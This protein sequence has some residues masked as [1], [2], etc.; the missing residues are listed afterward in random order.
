LPR[1]S[2]PPP[3]RT[4]AGCPIR[5]A[6][7]TAARD[8]EGSG[9]GVAFLYLP[10]VVGADRPPGWDRWLPA[11]RVEHLLGMSLD[12]IHDYLGWSPH[13]LDPHRLAAQSQAMRVVVMIAAKVGIEAQR[14]GLDQARLDE[15][16]RRLSGKDEPV[17]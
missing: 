7:K 17:E 9:G 13:E 2:A 4:M 12:R 1:H 3:V 16:R 15:L 10:R 8:A 5:R 11:A 14:Q 6:R